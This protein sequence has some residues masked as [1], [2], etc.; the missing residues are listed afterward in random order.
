MLVHHYWA[1]PSQYLDGPEAE[2]YAARIE[3]AHDV[4]V[5]QLGL[6]LPFAVGE[7]NR[8][9]NLESSADIQAALSEFERYWHY[10]NGLDYVV[11]GFYFLATNTDPAFNNLSLCRMPGAFDR[12]A[13]MDRQAEYDRNAHSQEAPTVFAVDCSNYSDYLSPAQINGLKEAGVGLVIVRLPIPGVERADL[14]PIARQQ[15]EALVAGGIPWQGYMWCYPETPVER[16]VPAVLEFLAPIQHTYH[17]DILWVDV[18]TDKPSFRADVMAWLRAARPLIEARGYAM[19]IYTS[20]TMWVKA[21]GTDEFA[22]C[23]L[24][25]ANDNGTPGHGLISY[26]GWGG[27]PLI[28]QY[29]GT[30]T[31]GGVT[32]DQNVVL[33]PEWLTWLTQ[34]APAQPEP[35]P[36][37]EL[38]VWLPHLDAAWG[39]LERAQQEIEQVLR[40]FVA[41]DLPDAV[42]AQLS[43]VQSRLRGAAGQAGRAARWVAP[44]GMHLTLAF[45]GNVDAKRIDAIDAAL[46]RPVG[47]AVPFTLRTA[48]LGAFPNLHRPHYLWVGL[49]GD[50]P[51]LDALQ[52]QVASALEG[53]GFPRERRRF[54]P[55][56]T[57]ARIPES[58]RP[59]EIDTFA[60]LLQ[61][62]PAP[63]AAEIPVHEVVLFR[64]ELRPTGSEYRRLHS[65]SL[66]D[67]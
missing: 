65:W 11:A 36:E 18:E 14:V 38:P 6:D 56:I 32:V 10:L 1:N 5:N 66:A 27:K 30:S 35:E 17:G 21:K 57:L 15:I 31:V 16:Q 26:G 48:R 61:R 64:S 29:W 28:H 3:R 67:R 33:A 59:D 43:E 53:V 22:D 40:L 7:F 49:A 45:L 60:R 63:E 58:A 24:W 20:A 4:I 13:G 37:P 47:A 44:E 34:A 54:T 50:L 41:I 2:W 25:D 51:R 12:L 55:H 8:P 39:A 46:S 23:P 9:V 62:S 42:K 52:D 19:G